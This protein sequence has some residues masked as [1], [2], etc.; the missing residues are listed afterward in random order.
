MDTDPSA[1][2]IASKLIENNIHHLIS[3][4]QLYKVV[5]NDAFNSNLEELHMAYIVIEAII[6]NEDVKNRL[7]L[8]LDKSI[9][10]SQVELMSNKWDSLKQM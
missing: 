2:S 5:G 10:T 8:E 1:L 7:F 4:G 3:K 6:E 9:Q